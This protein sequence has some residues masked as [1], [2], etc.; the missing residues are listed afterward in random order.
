MGIFE[1]NKNFDY[2]LSIGSSKKK[3]FVKILYTEV[4]AIKKYCKDE[5]L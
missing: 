4:D 3:S 5:R 1:L 2:A